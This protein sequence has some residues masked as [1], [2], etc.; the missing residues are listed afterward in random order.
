[1]GLL[2][3]D[4][5]V[6][7]LIRGSSQQQS[8]YRFPATAPA[9]RAHCSLVVPNLLRLCLE[10]PRVPS[11]PAPGCPAT[12]LQSPPGAEPLSSGDSLRFGERS[13]PPRRA[14]GAGRQVPA[15]A[16]SLQLGWVGGW[17]GGGDR[18]A[19]LVGGRGRDLTSCLASL[20]RH[21]VAGQCQLI[22]G[23]AWASED[24]EPSEHLQSNCGTSPPAPPIEKPRP[25][26]GCR[27]PQE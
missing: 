4:P 1:M 25:V 17:V 12:H 14:A 10:L 6:R 7:G 9:L 20:S 19:G 27:N 2:P 13:G 11:T 21:L 22:A 3:S 23:L 26:C 15:S 18:W 8:L 24:Q 5:V 16:K